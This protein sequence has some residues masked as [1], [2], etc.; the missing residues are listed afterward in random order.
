MKS[1]LKRTAEF[2][3]K[4][5]S[6]IHRNKRNGYNK[7][8]SGEWVVEVYGKD[9]PNPGDKILI[10]NNDNYLNTDA[11]SVEEIVQKVLSPIVDHYKGG[12]K[13]GNLVSI[14]SQDQAERVNKF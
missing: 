3:N 2:A 12:A 13:V 8:K 4:T 10:Q 1:L 7:S 9:D 5:A 14:I 6:K 11:S